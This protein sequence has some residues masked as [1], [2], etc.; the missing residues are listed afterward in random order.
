MDNLAF[1]TLLQNFAPDVYKLHMLGK[2]DSHLWEAIYTMLAANTS[3]IT[4]T[5]Q[6][7]YTRGLIEDIDQT[8]RLLAFKASR[9][10]Y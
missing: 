9:P 5:I 2:V 10:G 1:E 7:K 4:G 3:Q 6:I 8:T